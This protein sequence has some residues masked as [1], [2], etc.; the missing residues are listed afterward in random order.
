MHSYSLVEM[1]K[2]RMQGELRDP[3]NIL[4]PSLLAL[5]YPDETEG[6]H[7]ICISSSS[8]QKYFDVL[9]QFFVKASLI[10]IQIAQCHDLFLLLYYNFWDGAQ[11]VLNTEYCLTE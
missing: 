9:V 3:V 10:L 1:G 8:I 7:Q 2:D 4:C 6:S 5:K 11:H